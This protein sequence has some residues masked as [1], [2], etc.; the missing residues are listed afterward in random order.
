MNTERD[1][2]Y[3]EEQLAAGIEEASKMFL[4]EREHWG[5]PPIKIAEFLR[6]P[7]RRAPVKPGLAEDGLPFF[8]VLSSSWEVTIGPFTQS[9]FEDLLHGAVEDLVKFIHT[10][11][12][13]FRPYP[14][15]YVPEQRYGVAFHDWRGLEYP[16]DVRAVMALNGPNVSFHLSTLVARD[17]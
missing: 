10:T 1:H 15:T 2:S 12:E 13:V 8:E 17:A 7:I 4:P 16:F 6:V 11:Y 9:Q 3:S 5:E 14:I